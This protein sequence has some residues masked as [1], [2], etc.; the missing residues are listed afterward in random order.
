MLTETQRS[1]L[2]DHLSATIRQM[3]AATKTNIYSYDP[4]PFF[5]QVLLD[6]AVR[7]VAGQRGIRAPELAEPTRLSLGD[8][9]RQSGLEPQFRDHADSAVDEVLSLE[10]IWLGA[11]PDLLSGYGSELLRVTTARRWNLK[12]AAS[13]T[14]RALEDVVSAVVG[15]L[16]PEQTDGLSVFDPTCGVGA[17]LNAVAGLKISNGGGYRRV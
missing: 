14:S 15:A 13:L 3:D 12:R 4:A 9:V 11:H 10:A 8:A 2:R 5:S 1:A 7:F 17:L 16:V 6:H